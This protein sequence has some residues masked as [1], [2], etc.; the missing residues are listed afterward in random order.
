M[1][2][3]TKTLLAAALAVAAAG[4]DHIPSDSCTLVAGSVCTWAG[5]GDTAFNGDGYHRVQT[6]LDLPMDL[7]FGGPNGRAYILDWQN[8]RVRR[9]GA[10]DVVETVIGTDTA[11]DGPTPGP[12]SGDETQ[13]PGVPG[14]TVSLT[15]PTN[16][17]FNA[18]GMLILS[19]WGNDKM[20]RY[21][22]VTGLEEI[23]A[24]G[25]PG[26]SGDT[27]DAKAA[28]LSQPKGAAVSATDGSLYIIDAG[29]A[30]VRRIDGATNVIDTV[31]GSGT[32]GF[33]GDGGP[34]LGASF[35]F[36]DAAANAEPGGAVALDAGG[37]L[38]VA[39]TLNQRIRR[40]DFNTGEIDTFAGNGTAGFS[41]DG[42]AAT[43]ASL[44]NPRD[45]AFGRD[46]RLYIADT[47][48][49]CV[50][51]VDTITGIITT[52]AGQPGQSG[53]AGDGGEAVGALFNRPFGIAFD[54]TGDLY[55]ADTFNNRI[56]KVTQP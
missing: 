54:A 44:N 7:E 43:D 50:R 23:I 53:Y 10:A 47:D 24:G 34:P 1:L 41:G 48:N 13:D 17:V 26:F 49:H 52:V 12:T 15:H 16:V 40:I 42:G 32:P 25:Q 37:R 9:V 6:A 46:E 55:I 45:V 22:P 39:D 27:G 29:N 33:G 56:R 5:T 38:Y 4:C 31:A 21:D 11:G 2:A 35:A 20:R 30:R 19:A 51:A 36:Q 14:I 18:A 28:Q 3:S 8:H